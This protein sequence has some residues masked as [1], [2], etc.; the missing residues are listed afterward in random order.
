MAIQD[1]Q[2]RL[3]EEENK[4]GEAAIKKLSN[5]LK[6]V[7][8]RGWDQG[9][10]LLTQP[11]EDEKKLYKK[12]WDEAYREI[13][14][15]SK[16]AAKAKKSSVAKNII[17]DLK[18]LQQDIAKSTPGTA[19]LGE[20][21][22]K[23][24]EAV[25]PILQKRIEK[26]KSGEKILTQVKNKALKSVTG[27]IH[28]TASSLLSPLPFGAGEAIIGKV[29][30]MFGGG[31]AK[32]R[33]SEKA[34]GFASRVFGDEGDLGGGGNGGS[35]NGGGG[36]GGSGNGGGGKGGGNA[37]APRTRPPRSP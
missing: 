27:L 22:Q 15:E 21:I 4:S 7:Y 11:T 9:R 2:T 26:L 14:S 34:V 8:D 33:R 19:V 29:G 6:A 23:M 12:Y 18:S 30:G 13:L 37:A 17:G 31:G 10:S 5:E 32:E 20:G 35:G 24:I 1:L 36:N 28:S 25:Q 16:K 3:V